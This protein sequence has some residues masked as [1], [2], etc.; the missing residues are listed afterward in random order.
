LAEYV[1]QFE[2]VTITNGDLGQLIHTISSVLT[3]DFFDFKYLIV[4]GGPKSMIPLLPNKV[5]SDPRVRIIEKSDGNL[6]EGMNNA[7]DVS[8]GSWL[9]F[10]NAGD[11]FVDKHCVGR[12]IAS[13]RVQPNVDVH[14]FDWY[15]FTRSDDGRILRMRHRRPSSLRYILLKL[16]FCHQA[17]WTRTELLKKHRFTPVKPGQRQAFDHGLYLRL[18]MQGANFGYHPIITTLYAIGGLSDTRRVE[19]LFGNYLNT[20]WIAAR[21]FIAL[22]YFLLQTT[23]QSFAL[24][25]RILR[26][27]KHYM[28]SIKEACGVVIE[29]VIWTSFALIKSNHVKTKA[30]LRSVDSLA[31]LIQFDLLAH[32]VADWF[33]QSSLIGQRMGLLVSRRFGFQ[34]NQLCSEPFIVEDMLTARILARS[35]LQALLSCLGIAPLSGRAK[36]QVN[37]SVIRRF[38]AKLGYQSPY[39]AF[40]RGRSLLT[41]LLMY[42]VCKQILSKSEIAK[43]LINDLSYSHNYAFIKAAFD[44]STPVFYYSVGFKQDQLFIRAITREEN[45]IHCVTAPDHHCNY[46]RLPLKYARHDLLNNYQ[47]YMGQDSYAGARGGWSR[48]RKSIYLNLNQRFN[49]DKKIIVIFSHVLFDANGAYG[50]DLF[51]SM[52]AWLRETLIWYKQFGSDDYFVLVK[53]HPANKFKVASVNGVS[54]ISSERLIFNELQLDLHPERFGFLAD[55][56]GVPTPEVLNSAEGCITVRGSVAVEAAVHGIPVLVGGSSRFSKSGFIIEPLTQLEYF[57]ELNEF[58]KINNQQRARII[59]NATR[60]AECTLYCGGVSTKPWSIKHEKGHK[61]ELTKEDKI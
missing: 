12:M 16:P 54:P 48:E 43:L 31:V 49:T 38:P 32:S 20:R 19:A 36:S 52:E 11:M 27:A 6:W 7:L 35:V 22:S 56:D 23:I 9:L 57:L 30:S 1:D 3:Q 40:N 41:Y 39:R 33:R 26:S 8:V 25:P 44:T 34:P 15:T 18:W 29:A 13:V 42:Q 51:L 28:E 47:K 53:E 59:A 60:Y 55:Q 5:L 58:F 50:L 10:M 4:N 14:Y 24:A 2:I 61:P 17:T 46:H 21:P 45:L 37:S